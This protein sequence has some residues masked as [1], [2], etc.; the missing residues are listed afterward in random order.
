[1]YMYKIIELYLGIHDEHNDRCQMIQ[2]LPRTSNRSCAI[3]M[4]VIILSCNRRAL[5]HASPVTDKYNQVK[6]S[7]YLRQRT[8]SE[9]L[10]NQTPQDQSK[11][12]VKRGFHFT[13]VNSYKKKWPKAMLD[14]ESKSG[15]EWIRLGEV[16]L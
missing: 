2:F 8:F 7:W 10:L 4:L 15:K 9:T 13:R 14:I 16:P 3:T 6:T 12:P 5:S 1:M 11:C